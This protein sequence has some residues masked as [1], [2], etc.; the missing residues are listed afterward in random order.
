MRTLVQDNI[1]YNPSGTCRISLFGLI[2][3]LPQCARRT[4]PGGLATMEVEISRTHSG[5]LEENAP[6]IASRG[7]V[8]YYNRSLGPGSSKRIT[9]IKGFKSHCGVLI[10]K[11][12]LNWQNCILI[13][14]VSALLLD[15]LFCYI[16][17]MSD[18]E[19]CIKLDRILGIIASVLR[20][21]SDLCYM[22]SI[23]CNFDAR[24]VTRFVVVDILVVLPLPQVLVFAVIPKL[25][26]PR[27][28]NAAKF[29]NILF[30]IQY[31]LRVLRTCSLLK[32]FVRASGILAESAWANLSFFMLAS[33]ALG[34]FWYL[35]SIERNAS[36]WLEA[37]KHLGVHCSFYCDN[38]LRSST[39]LHDYCAANS[40]LFNFGIYK[41]ALESEVVSSDFSQRIF[42]CFWWGLQNLSSLGQS[43]KTSTYL[44]EVCFAVSVSIC[45]LVL[46]GLLIGNMQTYLLSKV[47]RSEDLRAKELD[48]DLWMHSHRLP[49][50]L[51]CQIQDCMKKKLKENT[52]IDVNNFLQLLPRV[53]R[54][55]IKRHICFNPLREV[56]LLRYKNEELLGA[57]CE[58]LEPVHYKK[59]SIIFQEGDPLIEMLFITRGNIVTH[60]T[61]AVVRFLGY[62][63]CYGEEL[64][65]WVLRFYGETHW[66]IMS[67]N[68]SNFPL[69][70]TTV[71][72]QTDVEVF[73]LRVQQLKLIV[74]NFWLHFRKDI[75][76]KPWAAFAVQKAFRRFRKRIQRAEAAADRIYCLSGFE[77]F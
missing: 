2:W 12:K 63:D 51:K 20:S 43:L 36:C 23:I 4:L 76:P 62:G 30:I 46:F 33:H 31:I 35:F 71:K 3:L 38:T 65:N 42:Y 6:R 47:A 57:I 22:H 58:Y 19:K 29:L 74:M 50:E 5:D 18:E 56:P 11:L 26:D 10:D 27:I 34:A 17:I 9:G 67:T 45:G 73:V 60:T 40:T 75:D 66:E 53:L 61:S 72:A 1:L 77:F 37:C 49:P 44:W 41:D 14:S 21:L 52:V 13:W 32:V 8:D 64:L 54:Q 24:S 68:I 55:D 59:N 39:L 28:Y 69:S 7:K 15:P 16:L 48:M 70:T 25:N